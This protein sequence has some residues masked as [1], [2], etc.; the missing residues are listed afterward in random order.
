MK[1]LY[2]EPRDQGKTIRVEAIPDDLLDKAKK[3]REKLFDTLTERDEKDLLTSA[4][5]EGKEI[6]AAT[7]RQAI[8]EQTLARHIQPVL[9]GSGREHI[10]VQPLL[11]AVT[12]YLPSPIDRPPV[13]GQ[14]PRKDDKA[15][16]RKPEPREPFCGLVFKIVADTHGELYYVRIYSGTL[17]ANSKV[18]NPGRNAKEMISKLYHTMADP[19][20]RAELPEA[21]A[22]DIVAVLGPKESITGDTLCETQHPLLLERIQFA[23]AVVSRSIEPES[24]ADKQKMTDILNLLKKEDP[25]FTWTVDRDT[26]QTLMNGMGMLHLEIKQHRMERD[27]RLKVRVGK[28]RVSY[29]ET[30]RDRKR[31]EGECIKHTGGAGGGLFAK[32]TVEVEPYKGD[33][34]IVVQTRIKPDVLPEAF[35]SAA[36]RGVRGALDSGELGYPVMHVK[37]TIV[38]GKQ[39]EELSNDVAFE[40]A[41]ADA[42]RK[43]MRDNMQLLEPWMR[44]QVEVPEAY[45]GSIIADINARRG[46][47][48]QFSVQDESNIAS[49]EAFVPLATLFDYADKLRSL[50]QGRG[51]STMEP[52]D[53]RAAPD[54][55][56]RRLLHPEEF[57]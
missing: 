47:V 23:Q 7:I 28:P 30:I 53:Y 44:L 35:L 43:A 32:V 15:E 10:G 3:Y 14:N 4:Y 12:Y 26:G 16:K 39:D 17:K 33:E 57:Y 40:A 46:E 27:F 19:H 13:E 56:L 11:D 25:T 18:M 55:V 41:G 48:Q 20:D 42:I 31:I 24:T 22:G 1:A 6:P 21:V 2:F 50:S 5:L 29:R 54:D 45:G 52:L 9:C 49:I 34:S 38:D 36:E 37:A 51:A 8:R